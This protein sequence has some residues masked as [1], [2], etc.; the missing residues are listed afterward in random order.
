MIVYSNHQQAGL[1]CDSELVL[2]SQNVFLFPIISLL[3]A[4]CVWWVET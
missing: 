1:T 2:I 4:D 3:S